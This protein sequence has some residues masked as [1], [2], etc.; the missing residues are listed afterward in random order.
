[1]RHVK[2][3]LALTLVG[4]ALS[5]GSTPKKEKSIV[6]VTTGAAKNVTRLTQ[7]PQNEINPVVSPDGKTVVFQ[8]LKN[9]QSDIWTINSAGRNLVQ[10]TSHPTNDIHPSW[11]P[12]SKTLVFS[13][14]RLG[15]YVL[16]RQLATGG[17]GTTMITKG[18]DMNDFAPSAGPQEKT[19]IA[20]TSKSTADQ[21]VV[22][23]GAKQYTVFEKNLPYIWTVNRDGSEL[24]Q[25]V[26]GAYPVWSPDGTRIA[27][28]SDISGNWDIWAMNNDGSA[29]TQLTSDPKNQFAPTYSPDGKWLAYTSNVGGN[30]DI[31]IMRNNG[32]D[33]TRLT[34]DKS[35]DVS[36]C[37]GSDGN[38]Y[39]SSNKAR[40]W[41]IW[42]LTPVL[43]E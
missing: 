30:Y 22:T 4:H 42:R 23:Q 20:F 5:C 28:S 24:T 33:P 16:W 17:G 9:G 12:D 40:N 41:D 34:M 1:M 32:S 2:V 7:T 6:V 15:S 10:V 36:P 29:L 38:I 3:L 11:L 27:F 25:F 14:N 43:P 13:S 37:R 39:F 31:W 19:K 8:S 35:E 26:Q 18:V 21:V